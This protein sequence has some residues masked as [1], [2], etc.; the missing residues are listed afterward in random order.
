MFQQVNL[1]EPI[2]RE[3]H[4]L[5]SAA[6]IGAA[7]GVVAA[8]ML[9]IAVFSGWRLA[10]LERQL[11]AVRDQEAAQQK[12]IART[13]AFIDGGE[14]QPHFEARLTAMAQDLERRQLALHYL[15][16]DGANGGD[17]AAGGNAAQHA[18]RGAN[19]GFAERLAALARQQLDGLWLTGVIFTAVPGELVLSGGAT[20]AA[21]VPAYLARLTNE[22]ALAGTSLQTIEIREPKKPVHG[23]IEFKVSSAAAAEKDGP[24]ARAGPPPLAAVINP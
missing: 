18:A 10:A 2:F 5:F 12:L 3:E 1:Y 7:L 14:S 11:A 20:S 6:T 15:R 24:T 17:A 21:L 4:K 23:E 16:G 19:R 9:T 22:P 13:D 8:G